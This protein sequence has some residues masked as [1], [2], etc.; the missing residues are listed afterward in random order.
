MTSTASSACAADLVAH[1][2]SRVASEE[3]TRF[4]R[5]VVTV[6]QPATPARAK[7][8][9]FAAVKLGTFCDERG[10]ELTSELLGPSMIERFVL[11]DHTLSHATARTLRANLRALS[12]DVLP[13]APRPVPLSRERAKGP[14]SEAQLAAYFALARVQRSELR[15]RRAE[16]LLCLGAGAGL[17]GSELRTV[18]GSDVKERSSGLVV[19]VSGKHA[20]SVPVLA[21]YHETLLA[22]ARFAGNR[23]VVGGRVNEA[24]ECDDATDW[25]SDQAHRSRATVLFAPALH[26]AL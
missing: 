14:Y 2:R 4:A 7:A 13:A 24:T 5:D 21:R 15:R 16:G 6:A 3:V 11:S 1:Y 8:F 22:S 17:I 19:V 9:L 23:Y 10:L 20:R 12:R 26:V 25:E 18:T